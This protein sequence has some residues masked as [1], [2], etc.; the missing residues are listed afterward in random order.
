MEA[1]NLI[2][3]YNE[4]ATE[5]K[6]QDFLAK[7]RWGH[8]IVC[9]K[10][11]TVGIK[12][13]KL[14]SGRLKCAECRSPFTVR[15]GSVFEDSKLPLQKW[16]FAIYLCTSLKKGVSSIQLSKYLGVTQKTAWFMLQRIRYVF[17]NGTFEKLKNAVE[18]D[19]AYIGGVEK[20]KHANKKTKGTQGFGSKKVKTPVV[21]MVQRGGKLHAVVT[22]DT[23]SATL[24]GLIIKHV[25]L[26]ATV[27][28]DEH[29][30][31]RTLPKLGYKHESVNHGSKEFVNGMASTNTAES[32]WSH[33]K[34]GIDGIYH[35]V[36]AK[37][38]QKYCDE[39]SY[40]WNTKDMADGERFEDWFSNINGKRLMY[41][42]LINKA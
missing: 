39:Y 2:E 20:N 21:G 36:S 37:H 26:D 10:C 30:P 3:F 6:C 35:H 34:R 16:F 15:M 33:L 40:R 17:E 1:T 11:G 12:A 25:D 13:Y 27:Y 8:K 41:K 38:L 5:E 31:Y 29:M 42:S 14:A 9:P 24:M 32:F 19:E 23:G 18:V 28:T 4:F 22:G 7:Q